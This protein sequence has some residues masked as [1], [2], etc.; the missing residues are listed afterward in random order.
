MTW[1]EFR[2]QC[3]PQLAEDGLEVGVNWAGKGARGYDLPPAAVRE[4]IEWQIQHLASS[5]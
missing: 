4:A 1:E 3:L 5:A 2:D